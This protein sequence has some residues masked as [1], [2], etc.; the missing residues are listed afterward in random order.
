MIQRFI[1]FLRTYDNSKAY[2][3]EEHICSAFDADTSLGM[4]PS[5]SSLF[6]DIALVA[7]NGAGYFCQQTD[8]IF[9]SGIAISEPL[10]ESKTNYIGKIF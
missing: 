5:V 7:R 2:N 3:C 9:L 10:T 1:Q 6:P 8:E 4:I